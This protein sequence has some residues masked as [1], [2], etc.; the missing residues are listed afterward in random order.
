M[1]TIQKQL[2]LK[3]I[4]NLSYWNPPLSDLFW[5][6]LSNYIIP[7]IEKDCKHI[8]VII[9]II[10]QVYLILPHNESHQPFY[11]PLLLHTGSPLLET[12]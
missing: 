9:T 3:Q 1:H 6:V 10:L 12:S 5:L 7:Q 8:L 4:Q 11:V 2:R